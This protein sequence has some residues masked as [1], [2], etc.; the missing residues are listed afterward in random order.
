LWLRDRLKFGSYSTWRNDAVKTSST[1]IV[2]AVAV[3]TKNITRKNT[4]VLQNTEYWPWA[5]NTKL[6]SRVSLY[7]YCKFWP[8]SISLYLFSLFNLTFFQYSSIY[9]FVVCTAFPQNGAMRAVNKI[10]FGSA[11]FIPWRFSHSTSLT[12]EEWLLG[13]S[14]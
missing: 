14:G 8:S 9:P 4:V 10:Y 13:K 11:K 6:E 7:S 2:T 12:G 5:W 3:R 1:V